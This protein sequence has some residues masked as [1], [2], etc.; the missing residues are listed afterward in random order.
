MPSKRKKIEA[1]KAKKEGR[2]L[3]TSQSG[4]HLVYSPDAHRFFSLLHQDHLETTNNIIQAC[5]S[6]QI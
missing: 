5:K 3:L 4:I 1:I 6:T 2:I